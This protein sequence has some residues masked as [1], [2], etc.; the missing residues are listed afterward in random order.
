MEQQGQ[1]E[2]VGAVLVCGAGIAG[3]QASLD[4]AQ[5]GFKVYLLESSAVI[6]GRMAQLDK[7]FPTGDCSLCVLSPRLVECARNRN[8]EIITLADIEEVSGQPGN[9]KVKIRQNP[10]Y[11]DAKKCDAC[12]DCTAVCPVDLPS[13]FE[14]GVA[15]QKAV[16]LAYPQAI[17]NI[18]T[19]AK[20]SGWAPCTACCPAGVNVQGYIALI[21]AGKFKEAFELIR[22]RCPFPAVSG[23]ICRHPCQEKCNRI[24]VDETV[25]ARNLE[26]F[27][28]DYIYAHPEQYPS[29]ELT[30]ALSDR[31]VA[32]VGG[33]PAGL[34]AAVDLKLKGY[35]VT[36]FEAK[37]QLGGMLQYGIPE[38][39]LPKEV[40]KKEIRQ[41]VDLEVEVLTGVSIAKPADLLKPSLQKSGSESGF[42][43]VFVATGAW[44][45]R[46]P[47]IPGEDADGVLECLQFLYEANAGKA[48]A[49]GPRVLVVGSTELA[50]DA[51][52]VARRLPGVESVQMAL[53]ENSGDLRKG[54]DFIAEAVKEGVE[55]NYGIGPTTINAVDGK[56]DSVTFR[57]CTSV[58]DEY[59]R[60]DPLFDDSSVSNISADTVMLT[61]GRAVDSSRTGLATRP[62]GRI[63][64][65]KNT[66]ATNIKGIFAGGDAVLGPAS[67]VDAIAHGHEAAESIDAYLRGSASIR[68]TVLTRVDPAVAASA[69]Q[70]QLARNPVSNAPKVNQIPMPETDGAQRRGNA[71][72]ALGYSRDQALAE[73]RRCLAC[74][75]CSEC[76]QCVKACSAE[77][78]IL[79]QEPAQF[80]IEVGS[81]ILAPGAEESKS[82]LSGQFG[83]GLY[84][85]VLSSLQFERMLTFAGPAGLVRRPSDGTT[86][87]R[88]AFIQCVGRTREDSEY[89]SSICCMN[90]AKQALAVMEHTAEGP[91]A[92]SIFFRDIRIVGKEADRYVQRVM[93]EQGVEYLPVIPAHVREIPE[94]KN[95]IVTYCTQDGVEQEREFDLVILSAKLEMSAHVRALAS[96]LG[97]QLN[98]FGFAQTE[99]LNP[100]ATSCPGI[101]MAG[102]FQ[103]PK[104]IPESVAQASGAAA[105][106]M[107]LL[108]EVRGTMTQPHEYPWERDSADE[109]PRIG[110][111]VCHC[112]HNIASVVDVEEVAQ[113]ASKQPG[114]CYAETSL[115]TCSDSSQQHIREMIKRHRL[116]R[117]VVASCSSRTHEAVFQETLRESGL[118]QYLFAMTNIRD[119]CSWVHKNNP[120]AA[121]AK[122]VDL[123]SMAVA[124]AQNLKAFPMTEIEVTAS[125]LVLGGGVAGMTAA[126]SIADQGFEV[127]LVE[128]EPTLGGLTRKIRGTLEKDKLQDDL[129]YLISRVLNHAKI[130]VHMNSTLI[131]TSGQVGGFTSVLKTQDEEQTIRHGVVI[132]ATGG[133]ERET[134]KYLCGSSP[135]VVT[136]SALESAF[137]G[138]SLPP[139]LR[140]KANPTVVMIQCVES[141][142]KNY[143]Y[144]SRVCCA[145]AIK[146]ALTIKRR[147]PHAAV[148]ILNRDIRTSG[149]RD[150]FFRRAREEGVQFVRYSRHAEPAVTEEVG[151]L[152]IEVHDTVAG[153]NQVFNADL[154]ALSTGIAPS[155]SNSQLSGMLQN[156]LTEDGFFLEAHSK[157]RPV[158]LSNEGEFVCGLAHSPRF[159]EETIAQAQAAAG[160]ASRILSRTLL[161]IVSGVSYVDPANC[162]ACATCVKTC[163][164]GAPMINRLGKAEIQGA[165]CVGCGSCVA[166]CPA[167]AIALQHQETR[168]VVAMLDQVLAGG[169]RG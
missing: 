22:Q 55:I 23:R 167:R 17:P 115:Y 75:L 33:G 47:G 110:V 89:C 123:V 28:A 60:F 104:D 145:E 159:I 21:A 57:A 30:G 109:P 101:Y 120:A 39:R 112:G 83:Y 149:L 59:K 74:G 53:L 94:S 82:A 142:D 136:Q 114:V 156:A 72:I 45:G 37:P 9:F 99:R 46:K 81:I 6:G 138:G 67:L 14:C 168:T 105:C 31:K 119:Q 164:Y 132:V 134:N 44:L 13:E 78:V 97:I 102:S 129:K 7:T 73:S 96:R 5:S 165:K 158:D 61:A 92:V 77:A 84:P 118:N 161:E 27:V 2:K 50:I 16:S 140:G 160:R 24:D 79:D 32:I 107:G 76:M 8:I 144:C 147:I 100:L 169:G 108:T 85:N 25:A 54:A 42:D 48:Q 90:T 11:I 88:I 125:G 65:D 3:I 139:E 133:R 155:A 93:E 163:P 126:L 40:L 130:H 153:R 71:E 49:V 29:L 124:R 52:R 56:V 62:G 150:D 15:T 98:R 122:A 121:T 137:A 34:T 36:V 64:A 68:D 152:R 154:L 4:L 166:A 18:F 41:I 12:G 148:I 63:I 91:V 106:A 103:E 66:L 86:A 157:L 128:K 162:V 1:V 117:L 116:N 58:Y 70:A 26:R 95:L 141:R 113:K 35:G 135:R 87:K 143:P 43:A 131:R 10:R 146:N 20:A 51:A 19:I 127:H 69:D 38:Y 80:E 111:F 151:K